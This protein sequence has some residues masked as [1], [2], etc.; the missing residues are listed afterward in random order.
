MC[1]DIT[2][3]F[4]IEKDLGLDFR[5]RIGYKV[6]KNTFKSNVFRGYYNLDEYI[7]G[8]TYYRKELDPFSI[9]GMLI[10]N[11]YYGFHIFIYKEDAF[12]DRF[13]N[14]LVIQ[15]KYKDVVAVGFEG[16]RLIVVSDE[17]ELMRV[18]KV[19]KKFQ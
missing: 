3:R 1:L 6:F 11:D 13:M 10:S 17:I 15:V 18:L 19:P 8:K 5:N 14:C 9:D 16:T 12:Q 4:V 2:K 7:M